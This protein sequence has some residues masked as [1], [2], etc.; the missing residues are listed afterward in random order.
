MSDNR[1]CELLESDSI[2]SSRER[3]YIRYELDY[4]E[5]TCRDGLVIGTDETGSSGSSSDGPRTI[6]L[7]GDE[8]TES[9][10][11]EFETW[12]CTEFLEKGPVLVEVGIFK[13]GDELA[14]P[15]DIPESMGAG[16][17]LFDGSNT[18]SIAAFQRRGLEKWWVWGADLDYQFKLDTDG[19]GAYYNFSGVEEGEKV[20]PNELFSCQKSR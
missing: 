10:G 13:L 11:A 2:T 4:R 1:L 18:G 15:A 3:Q 9:D 5:L 17:I 6:V 20:K 19:D 8:Y 16:F 14:R 7:D 12:K